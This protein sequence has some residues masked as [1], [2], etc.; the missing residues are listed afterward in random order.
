MSNTKDRENKGTLLHF[1]VEY[2][3]RDHPELLSFYDELIHL[4]P[5]SRVSV[6]TIQKVLK[7]MDSSI[8]NLEMDLKN[9]SRAAHEPDDRYDWSKL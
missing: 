3:E 1:L 7:Q 8:K 4:D 5:A 9:A 6:E 2:V